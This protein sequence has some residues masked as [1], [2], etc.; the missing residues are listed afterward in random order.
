MH[1]SLGYLSGKEKAQGIVSLLKQQVGSQVWRSHSTIQYP[2]VAKPM[3][4]IRLGRDALCSLPRLH[5]R[6]QMCAW[7]PWHVSVLIINKDNDAFQLIARCLSR[8]NPEN[9]WATLYMLQYRKLVP[10]VVSL[11]IGSMLSLKVSLAQRVN[12]PLA[13]LLS[14]VPLSLSCLPTHSLL[15]IISLGLSPI[16]VGFSDIWGSH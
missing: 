3:H 14:L 4:S 7:L 2:S 5:Q 8:S 1:E 13:A 12:P 6:A 10:T 11:K 16:T 9:I 15:Y